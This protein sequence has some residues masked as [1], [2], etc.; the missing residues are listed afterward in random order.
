M[1]IAQLVKENFAEGGPMFMLLIYILWLMV[2]IQVVRFILEF[3][4]QNRK[5]LKLERINL[6]ILFIG[7]FSVLLATFYRT[8]GLYNAF[9]VLENTS[10]ISP[11]L[12]AGGFK[13]SLIA[14]LYSLLL[15]LVSSMVWFINKTKMLD[16]K[17]KVD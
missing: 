6:S 1:S 16:S 4:S 7:G 13:A 9:S 14:P 17:F 11:T 12:V 2:F 15:F 10:D 5:Q 8:T 3:K